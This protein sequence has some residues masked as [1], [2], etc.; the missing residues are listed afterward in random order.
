LRSSEQKINFELM[1]KEQ[2]NQILR[3]FDGI[4]LDQMDEVKLMNRVDTKFAFS[5]AQFLEFLPALMKE[6]R[7]LE[8]E[9]ARI[10]FYESLYL[11]DDHFTFFKD[12]HKGKANRYKVRF[13]KYVESNIQFLEIKEKV[14]GRT[15]KR[16]IK[17]DK[18]PDQL[19]KTHIEFIDS[20]TSEHYDLHPVMWNSFNRITLVNKVLK[21][22]LTLDFNLTFKW[23][24][25]Y[26]LFENL[27]IAELKQESIDRTSAFFTLMKEKIIRPY[28]LSKYCIGSIE[29][30][31]PGVLK[32]NR[33][34]K[35]LLTL[36]K[37]NDHAS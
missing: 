23:E 28:R 21:E 37:I 4:T 35:K 34:K 27:I 7:V 33:F 36:K 5:V 1:L 10:S 9:G 16:R 19:D 3:D 22:R 31:G 11:D 17:V 29:L 6:Y 18:I 15:H 26:H 20:V 24:G 14:K 30:Y 25:E 32:F 12:H 13:R 8:I 2:I